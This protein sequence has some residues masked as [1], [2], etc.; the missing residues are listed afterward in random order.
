MID[1]AHVFDRRF[2]G[3]RI[4]R[5]AADGITDHRFGGL[6]MIMAAMAMT[7]AVA[8]AVMMMVVVF[9]PGIHDCLLCPKGSWR[10]YPPSSNWKVKR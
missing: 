2:A 1:T 8:V 3:L 5:H 4:D 9:V 7:V 6:L 10:A